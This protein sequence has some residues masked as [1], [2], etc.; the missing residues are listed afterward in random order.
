[1]FFEMMAP[2]HPIDVANTMRFLTDPDGFVP[3]Q[4]HAPS[5]NLSPGQK[6]RRR[7]RR[8]RR[9]H[10]GAVAPPHQS[11]GRQTA[12]MNVSLDPEGP[13]STGRNG[14]IGESGD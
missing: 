6:R 1:M 7:R 12:T 5:T 10:S 13:I 4:T 2:T 9:A 11:N 8:G 14:V 3:A